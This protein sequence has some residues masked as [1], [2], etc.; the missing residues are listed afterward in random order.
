MN[1]ERLR[2]SSPKSAS[3]ST[4]SPAYF[5][6]SSAL[7]HAQQGI[8][9]LAT[10]RQLWEFLDLATRRPGLPLVIG[11]TASGKTTVARAYARAHRDRVF[12]VHAQVALAKSLNVSVAQV[13]R[14]ASDPL[15]ELLQRAGK[16]KLS[17]ERG[18]LRDD[19]GRYVQERYTESELARERRRW[20]SLRR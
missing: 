14:L 9:P 8:A 6:P 10:T 11:D 4:S 7:P 19:D 16:S 13:K 15:K 17:E 2:F 5:A 20:F 18:W 3:W 1:G 12:Y